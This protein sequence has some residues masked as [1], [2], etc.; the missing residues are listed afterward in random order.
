MWG[1][2][3][4]AARMRFAAEPKARE[5][6]TKER[7]VVD[8]RLVY[9]AP[10]D[11]A[12]APGGLATD[13]GESGGVE[14][15]E[16]FVEIPGGGEATGESAQGMSLSGAARAAGGDDGMDVGGEGLDLAC[17]FGE[18]Q[19]VEWEGSGAVEGTEVREA[20]ANGEE[21]SGE[22]EVAFEFGGGEEFDFDFARGIG[23]GGEM[24]AAGF[25]LVREEFD[26]GAGEAAEVRKGTPE[27]SGVGFKDVESEGEARVGGKGLSGEM[28]GTESVGSRAVAE[29]AG[30]GGG[31]GSE[32]F[33]RKESTES[34]TQDVAG[35][36]CGKGDG[37]KR[38]ILEPQE[39]KGEV[40][41]HGSVRVA[42][43]SRSRTDQRSSSPRSLVLKTRPGTG[44]I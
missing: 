3:V 7:R 9:R 23:A 32:V 1:F 8:T 37:F 2:G 28:A 31:L 16:K 25:E 38:L 27:G 20:I 11:F 44:R 14:E 17:V 15:R 36:G 26:G 42:E 33:G 35:K 24:E 30:S 43:A 12:F 41:R 6:E 40:E 34:A 5:E 39:M 22:V 10:G 21:E 29:P 18:G 19:V 13:A 4:A